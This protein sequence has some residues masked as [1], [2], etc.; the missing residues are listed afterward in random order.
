MPMTSMKN[1]PLSAAAADLGL[2]GMTPAQDEQNAEEK[3]KRL[4]TGMAKSPNPLA[5]SQ[6]FG[7]G[8]AAALDLGLR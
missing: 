6:L 5:A 8:G 3:R 4:M 1:Y 7:M 2:Q